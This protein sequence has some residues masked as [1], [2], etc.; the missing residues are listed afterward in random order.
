M[1]SGQELGGE[2]VSQVFGRP[3]GDRPVR[4][5]ERSASQH[6][7]RHTANARQLDRSFGG[8]LTVWDRLFGTFEPE[9]E[10]LVYGTHAPRSLNPLAL[11]LHEC[12]DIARDVHVAGRRCGSARL[13][14]RD[15]GEGPAAMQTPAR[16]IPGDG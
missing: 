11:R 4:G 9:R 5:V 12:A 8:A 7:V 3:R 10:A 15:A 14:L 1:A 6:R 13:P 2:R 16:V